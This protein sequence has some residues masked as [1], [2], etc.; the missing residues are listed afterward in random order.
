MLTSF[1]AMNMCKHYTSISILHHNVYEKICLRGNCWLWWG[2][3]LR[4][5]FD[6]MGG[7]SSIFL[8]W[9]GVLCEIVTAKKILPDPPS[10][11]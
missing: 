10:G 7:S 3:V 1:P 11:K 4:K 6:M 8:T 5:I 9:W 2:G